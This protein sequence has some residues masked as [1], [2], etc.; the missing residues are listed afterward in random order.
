M[1]TRVKLAGR[2]WGRGGQGWGAGEVRREAGGEWPMMASI[3]TWPP[4]SP[5]AGSRFQRRSRTPPPLLPPSS[6]GEAKQNGEVS[7]RWEGEGEGGGRAG[8][9]TTSPFSA[10]RKQLL[11]NVPPEE[12]QETK[13][14]Y[15]QK[16]WSSPPTPRLHYLVYLYCFFSLFFP[17]DNG[18]S[19]T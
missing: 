8:R 3:E 6:G 4:P 1:R 15:P 18:G 2:G 16:T 19:F 12:E 13:A 17:K 9:R 10:T 7:A 5:P 14:A 11:L